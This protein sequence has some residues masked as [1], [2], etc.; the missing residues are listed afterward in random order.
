MAQTKRKRRTKHRGN[1]AGGVE[2]RGRT[3]RKPTDQERRKGS[4]GNAREERRYQEPTWAGAATRAGLASVLLFVLF[5]SGIAGQNQSAAT[6]I[7]LSVAAF[8]IYV[9]MG[10]KVDRIFWERRMR[11]AGPRRSR[12]KQ[13]R[14]AMDVRTFTVGP[15]QENCH[16]ARRDGSD[17]AIVFDPG[18][19][20]PR[21]L[22]AIEALELNVGA[23]LLTHT[24]FD[25]VG[26]V[27]PLARATG[28]DVW[29]PELEVPVLADIM[30]YV[31]WPGFGPFESYDADHTVA[32]GEQLELAGFEIDVVFTPGHSPG[33]VTYSIPAEQAIFSGDVLF[34]GSIGRTDLPGGDHATLMRSLA[35]LVESLPDE[36]VVYPGHMG[37]TTIGRERATNPFLAQLA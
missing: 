26:A 34:E 19:E 1:A 35:T 21:L 15:V 22:E 2:A 3:G 29:C 20:A 33:H 8:L 13:A 36:T 30:R 31:P 37:N 14:T 7:A 9:P 27:A 5:I 10:Y 16:I 18:D 11:K 12:P 25:H 23:I 32:G 17:Q 4:C 24:H 28:A 6:A